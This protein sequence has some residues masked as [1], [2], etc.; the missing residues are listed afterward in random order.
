MERETVRYFS[1]ACGD[2]YSLGMTL[3]GR[4]VYAGNIGM[5]EMTELYD[6]GYGRY[7]EMTD[8]ENEER[9]PE[10]IQQV[11]A[12]CDCIAFEG[13]RTEPMPYNAANYSNMHD[14]MGY[15]RFI[16]ENRVSSGRLEEGRLVIV[17]D[18]VERTFTLK[19]E[20]DTQ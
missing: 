19:D 1:I 14:Y 8:P 6:I 15:V 9:L 4:Y 2:G 17:T 10:L 11:Y 18:K 12:E 20:E 16:A 13:S 7:L 3:D 5:T